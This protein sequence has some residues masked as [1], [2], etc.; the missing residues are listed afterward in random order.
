MYFLAISKE[1][2]LGQVKTEQ[3]KMPSKMRASK[4]TTNRP[5]THSKNRNG[6][7][8]GDSHKVRRSYSRQATRSQ[9]GVVATTSQRHTTGLTF[10]PSPPV[11]NPLT[12]KPGL[13]DLSKLLRKELK[14]DKK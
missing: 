5:Y 7:K 11:Q 8:L 3:L 9:A 12:R 14:R 10:T 1:N 6:Q 13:L 4:V 2:V